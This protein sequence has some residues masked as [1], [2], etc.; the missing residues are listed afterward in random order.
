LTTSQ[1][2]IISPLSPPPVDSSNST[3]QQMIWQ[4][5]NSFP[6]INTG[7]HVLVHNN[8][9]NN[10][11]AGSSSLSHVVMSNPYD[12]PSMTFLQ[13]PVSAASTNGSSQFASFHT[14]S[15]VTPVMNMNMNVLM[16]PQ[17]VQHQVQQQWI[18]LPSTVQHHQVSNVNMNSPTS[19]RTVP[20]DTNSF[21]M[22]TPEQFYVKAS[23]SSSPSHSRKSSVASAKTDN[24]HILTGVSSVKSNAGDSGAGAI[25]KRQR[26]SRKAI[27]STGPISVPSNVTDSSSIVD[28]PPAPRRKSTIPQA[29]IVTVIIPATGID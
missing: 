13:T 17:Q 18:S 6:M 2:Q 10:N 28:A 16:H 21:I 9:V 11:N 26:K 5:Q 4:H 23:P 1:H 24:I 3:L 25:K 27:T 29:P 14:A 22:E 15:P 20:V 7:A 19:T 8:N 12:T